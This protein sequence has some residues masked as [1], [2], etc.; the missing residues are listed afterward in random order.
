MM[1]ANKIIEAAFESD[2]SFQNTLSK[3]VKDELGLT[4]AEFSEKA[5]VPVSTLYKILSGNREPNL[6]TLRQIVKTADNLT[7]SEPEEFIG[8]IA[9]RPVLDNI[10]ETKRKVQGK[11]IT[12]R[13][14]SATSIEDAIIVA[15]QA[16]REGAKALVCAP[17]V[18]STVEKIIRVPVTTIMPRKSIVEAIEIA[19]Q[20]IGGRYWM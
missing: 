3:V 19:V 5:D 11:N 4:I 17:I 10:N 12:I 6:K 8:V 15:V 18:S 9:A 1:P 14:Y 2:E 20:K 16:E 13:E 7:K